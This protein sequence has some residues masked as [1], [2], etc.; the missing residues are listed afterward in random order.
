MNDSFV[1][2]A[3]AAP[4]YRHPIV[5]LIIAIPASAVVMGVVIVTLAIN[6]PESVVRDDYY[7]AGRAINID[8]RGTHR[9]AELGVTATLLGSPEDGWLL[10]VRQNQGRPADSPLEVLFAHPT[11]AGKDVEFSLPR[12]SSGWSGMIEPMGGRHVLNIRSSEDH[13]LLREEV[14]LEAAADDSIKVRARP[15][16]SSP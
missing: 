14:R 1:A 2:T 4:W 6:V 13:W 12:T 8:L 16:G 5:W 11:Q 9:A 10:E 7:Q 15:W 3:P